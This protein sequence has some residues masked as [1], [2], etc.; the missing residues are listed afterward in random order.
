MEFDLQAAECADGGPPVRLQTLQEP[1]PRLSD[2]L[3]QPG[4]IRIPDADRRRLALE[5]GIA[6]LKR[7][8]VSQPRVYELRFHVEHRPV[9]PAP[10]AVSAFL[11]QP[12]N[13]R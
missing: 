6:L 8:G 4:E 13:T 12:V 10:A 5:R 11:N 9:E 2:G 3:P 1:D 7:S